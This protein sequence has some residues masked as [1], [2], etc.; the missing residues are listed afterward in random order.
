MSS[1]VFFVNRQPFSPQTINGKSNK[2]RAEAFKALDAKFGFSEYDIH[3]Y[4][5]TIW[6][7]GREAAIRY[8]KLELVYRKIL[9]CLLI[10]WCNI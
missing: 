6:G 7:N 2:E 9:H 10:L 3:L 1:A 4:A 8:D 5:T